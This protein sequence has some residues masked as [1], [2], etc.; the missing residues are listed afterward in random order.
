MRLHIGAIPE[1]GFFEPETD[2]WHSLNEPGPWA[3]QLI[4]IPI[5][6]VVAI[7]LMVCFN[8]VIPHAI[9]QSKLV[10]LSFQIWQ[11]FLAIFLLV[12]LH[13]VIHALCYPFGGMTDQTLIGIWPQRVLIYAF[14]QGPMSRGRY[15]F[16]LITPFLLLSF[17]PVALIALVQAK[18][19]HTDFLT[20][21][22]V[23]SILNGIASSADILGIA[24]VLWRL[25]RAAVIRNR[26][27]KSYWKNGMESQGITKSD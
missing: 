25:P 27:W 4:T 23:V 12:P 2:G 26:G 7:F 11:P 18:A 17:L 6:I 24:M 21:L 13:E 10:I 19:M 1:D 8:A 3:I 15:I 5:A 16:T 20:F 22:I 9:Y 14:F